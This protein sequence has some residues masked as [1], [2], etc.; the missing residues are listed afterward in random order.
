MP[1]T[2]THFPGRY[3]PSNRYSLIGL[4]GCFGK[5]VGLLSINQVVNSIIL[6]KKCFFF[7]YSGVAL[8]I[9]DEYGKT[10]YDYSTN[11]NQECKELLQRVNINF[12]M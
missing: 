11:S 5:S 12:K 10:A 1:R 9:S 6:L 3:P 4:G 7:V 2:D 8:D